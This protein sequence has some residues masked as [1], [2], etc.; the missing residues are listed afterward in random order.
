METV[1]FSQPSRQSSKGIIV[2]FAFTAI[3]LFR[4]FFAAFLALG[5]ALYRKNGILGLSTASLFLIGLA[6]LLLILGVAVLKYLN[7]KFH[8]S[9]TD[10]HLASGIL[11]KDTTIIP[12]SKIQN[13][14]LKQTFLQQII[15]VVSLKIETAGDKKSEIEI[16][17]LD[18]ATALSL[19]KKLFETDKA[20]I[21]D[22]EI[23]EKS[24]IF[25]KISNVRL[26][27]EGLFQ[28]HLKSFL[29]IAS[30]VVGL[31]Y[32]FKDYITPIQMDENSLDDFANEASISVLFTNLVFVLI[33][34]IGLVLFSVIKVFIINYNLEVTDNQK[35]IEINKG[36]FNKV[37][38]V[39]VPSRIQN[40]EIK[41]NRLKQYFNL[42]TM[43]VKQ[44]MTNEKDSKNFGIIGLEKGQLNHL[45]NQLLFGYGMGSDINKPESYYKRILALRM[46]V[47]VI[48]LNVLGYLFLGTVAFWFNALLIPYAV[49]FAYLS[50]KK[51]YFNITNSFITIGSGAID[52][53]TNVLE[54]SRIQAV[55]LSQSFFQKRKQI[56]SVVIY[57][58]SKSVVIPYINEQDAKK[59]HDFLLFKVESQDKDW[60]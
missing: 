57:T 21:E 22:Q 51:A 56:A 50:Y 58:A 23:I 53:T 11:K 42:H 37:S 36:L 1:D 34:V 12:K 10:F 32:E 19:K 5:L 39:L 9:E 18:R 6:I 59:I 47:I 35:K 60:M 40:I 13:V 55:K 44:A 49:L 4:T 30:F 3:K 14:Y 33:L 38:L 45:L 29:I 27:L 26:L 43:F 28:N 31:Y 46:I 2:I 7:F 52:T 24:D 41:T 48:F 20:T 15:N 25:F 8:L 17:A 54:I 16:S